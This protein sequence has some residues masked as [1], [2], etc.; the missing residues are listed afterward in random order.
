MPVPG[1]IHQQ[2]RAGQKPDRGKREVPFSRELW[3]ERDDFTL[4][5]PKGYFRL[6]PGNEVRLRFGYVVKC[7]GIDNGVVH[8]THYP[9]SKS[10]TPGADKYKVKGNIHWVSARHA[11]AST[12]HLYDRLFRVPNPGAE[13]DFIEDL[14]PDSMK[15]ITAQLEPSLAAAKPGEGLQ[16]ERHGYFVRDAA[17]GAFN[18]TVTLRDSWSKS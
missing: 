2:V 15:S 11:Q 9:D 8:C 12:V 6:Y 16:F 13:R 5:P 7:T 1:E 10:G 17:G 14:N 4:E 18:R 3:I